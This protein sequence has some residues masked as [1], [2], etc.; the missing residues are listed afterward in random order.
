MT[1]R[2]HN[3]EMDWPGGSFTLRDGQ[4]CK[5]VNNRYLGCASPTDQ[6][7]WHRTGDEFGQIGFPP[8]A[9]REL[10]VW[11]LEGQARSLFGELASDS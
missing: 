4:N 2:V 6:F 8:L 1:R 11:L 5:L 9:F 3:L 7:W 10:G